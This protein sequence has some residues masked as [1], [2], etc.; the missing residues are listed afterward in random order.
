MKLELKELVSESQ[1]IANQHG[2]FVTVHREGWMR[3]LEALMLVVTELSEAAEVYREHKSNWREKF[4][5]EIADTFIRLA[6]LCGD[7]GI[8]IEKAILRK[9]KINEKRP[10]RHGKIT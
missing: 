7:L 1:R 6:H 8:D 9:M 3:V 10:Y 4:E 2:F 5:E